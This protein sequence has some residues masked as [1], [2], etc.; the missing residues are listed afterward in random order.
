[1][2]Q[3]SNNRLPLQ[4]CA[5]MPCS[6][7]VHL[8]AASRAGWPV[9]TCGSSTPP[10]RPPAR[11][12]TAGLAGYRRCAA[13]ARNPARAGPHPARPVN[14]GAVHRRPHRAPIRLPRAARGCRPAPHRDLHPARPAGPDCPAAA[15]HGGTI[16]TLPT[17]ALPSL[18]KAHMI[19]SGGEGDAR[20]RRLLGCTAATR[21][22]LTWMIC[23][24]H[25]PASGCCMPSTSVTGRARSRC[26][27][28]GTFY[29]QVGPLGEE[30][31]AGL[32]AP[33]SPFPALMSGYRHCNACGASRPAIDGTASAAN[34]STTGHRTGW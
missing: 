27:R 23:T 34:G 9:R 12:A 22:T 5:S 16:P 33:A 19:A 17:Q 7:S 31:N 15:D 25:S 30:I 11:S 8:M 18:W 6:R 3:G 14:G 20:R 24:P 28:T 4:L 2:S 26:P 10:R 21:W 32:A 13:P 29:A 1:M